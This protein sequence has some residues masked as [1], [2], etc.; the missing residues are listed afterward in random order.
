ML[1]TPS[2]VQ[3]PDTGRSRAVHELAQLV[4]TIP[5]NLRDGETTSGTCIPLAE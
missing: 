2:I 1:D 5:F 4:F 3:G